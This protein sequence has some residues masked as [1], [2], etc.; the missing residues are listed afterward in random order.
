MIAVDS[1][2]H[3]GGGASAKDTIK[4]YSEISGLAVLMYFLLLIDLTVLSN[5]VSAFVLVC[6]QMF[7]E[8]WLFLVRNDMSTLT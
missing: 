7:A 4:I 8:V 3:G 5:R 2:W 6:S 1:K